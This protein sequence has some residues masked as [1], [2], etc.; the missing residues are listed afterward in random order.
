MTVVLASLYSGQC[1][2]V[3]GS[4][5]SKIFDIS[6]GTK[7]GDPMSPILFNSVLQHV[8]GVLQPIWRQVLELTCAARRTI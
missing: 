8:V 3:V 7:Q 1:G 2:Q 4:T 5:S 6:R